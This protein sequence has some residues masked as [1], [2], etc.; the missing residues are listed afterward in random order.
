MGSRKHIEINRKVIMLNLDT[1]LH[2]Y[3]TSVEKLN[4][5]ETQQARL[6]VYPVS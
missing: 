2:S 4:G 1:S 5:P 6:S 3:S